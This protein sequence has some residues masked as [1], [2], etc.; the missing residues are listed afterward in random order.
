MSTV[1]TA[2]V[3]RTRRPLLVMAA[4]AIAPILA[5]TIAYHYFPRAVQTNYGTLLG[6]A[7]AADITAIG[8]DGKPFRL[9][10][11]HG[12]WVMVVAAAGACDAGCERELYA[13][14]QARTMQGKDQDRVMRVWLV[15][16]AAAP[17]APLI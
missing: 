10:Q 11:L 12:R 13:T 8:L 3:R 7:P 6:V 5:S 16:D 14:R 15:T 2:H 9:S 4:I 17:R 1:P